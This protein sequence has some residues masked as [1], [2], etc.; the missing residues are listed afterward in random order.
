MGITWGSYDKKYE[1][2]YDC[3][4]PDVSIQELQKASDLYALG[5]QKEAKE[6]WEKIMKKYEIGE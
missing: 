3:L 5:K 1:I 4:L 2:C 6:I